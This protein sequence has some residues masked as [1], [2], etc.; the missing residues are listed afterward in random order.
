MTSLTPARRRPAALLAVTSAGLLLSGCSLNAPNTAIQ[1][2]APADGL[3]AE[4]GEVLVRNMLVV[5]EGEGEPGLLVGA[6]VNRGQEDVTVSLEVGETSVEVDVPVGVSVALGT[7]QDRPDGE[8]G[9]I[10]SEVVEIDEVEP[11]SGGNLELTVTAPAGS[12]VLQVPVLPPT[13]A[14]DGYAPG[15]TSDGDGSE[16][17]AAVDEQEESE[18]QEGSGAEPS[19]E[20]TD[21]SSAEPSGEPSG[22][23][24]AAPGE[25]G[26]AEPS[27]P[28]G[29]G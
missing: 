18:E 28:A 16:Q 25:L 29:Q 22:E 19:G 12:A 5:S 6:L 21:G 1:P 3:Q 23:S 2:Y 13:G 26:V 15:D 20:P 8:I 14:Y 27:D 10:A 24:S 7:E 17:D 11:A 4:L 9:S